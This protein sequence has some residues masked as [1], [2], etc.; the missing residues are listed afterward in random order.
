MTIYPYLLQENCWV[1]DDEQNQLKQE[2]FVMGAS[3]MITALLATKNIPN[4]AEGFQ[5]TFSDEPFDGHDV[6]LELLGQGDSGPITGNWYKGEIAGEIME[7]WLCPALLCFFDSA[8]QR[9]YVRA[10]QLPAGIDPIW[11]VDPTDP[12]QRRFMSAEDE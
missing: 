1:F 2:A 9:L 8:P 11:Q 5:M 4:A 6:Q 7:G 12:R 3:E 10:D